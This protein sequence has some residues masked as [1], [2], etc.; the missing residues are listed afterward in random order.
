[1]A[2]QGKGK[3]HH[4]QSSRTVIY[5]SAKVAGDSAFPFQPGDDLVIRIDTKAGRLIVE[6]A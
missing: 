4:P 5:V 6:K 1:M 2:L 3:L